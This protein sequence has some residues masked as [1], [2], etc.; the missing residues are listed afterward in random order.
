[1]I[2]TTRPEL[3]PACVGVTAHPDDKRYQAL[4]GKEAVTPLFRVP[5]P[6]FPSEEADPEK[7]TGILMVC[8]FG[9]AMD[10]EWWQKH[11]LPLRQIV[12]MDGRLT[13]ASFGA[14]AAR[15]GGDGWPSLDAAAA[16]AYYARIAGKTVKQAQREIV[17]IL[18]DPN[19][20]AVGGGAPLQGEPEPMQ[21]P[22][23]Y[24]EKGERPLELVT[25]RQWF[26]RL[27]DK[28]EMLLAKGREV[29]WHPGYMAARYANWTENLQLDWCISRQRFFGVAFPGVVPDRR[30]AARPC[31][32]SRSSPTPRR[33][34]WTR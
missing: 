15:R 4:F 13:P 19:G 28:K 23:R 32:T 10:V 21:H 6:I 7:G 30:N 31:T 12:G 24:Y 5:V 33:C 11:S 34:P 16:N 3:L 29:T 14:R 27:L 25:T 9:D 8:T 22:V 17:E 2:A 26:V 1:M 20:G 18:R